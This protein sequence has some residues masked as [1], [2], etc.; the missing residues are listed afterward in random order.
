MQEDAPSDTESKPTRKPA[1]RQKQVVTEDSDEDI[2][3]PQTR[4]VEEN[5]GV[6]SEDDTQAMSSSKDTGR[7]ATPPRAVNNDGGDSD[8]SSVIDES[9]VKRR[10]QNTEKPAK[11]AKGAKAKA[12]PKAK[13]AKT[14]DDP[15]Q[16]EIKR[17][18]GWLVKCGIRKVWGKEL[19]KCDTPKD[20]IRHLKGLLKEAGMDGK[21][22][23]EK[24]A[25]IKEQREFAKDLEEIQAGAAAWGETISTGRPRRAAARPRQPVILPEDSGEEEEKAQGAK[26]DGT[27]DDDD[28][29]DEVHSDSGSDDSAGGQDDEN[30]DEDSE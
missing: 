28:D 6:E 22:S 17:L 2:A 1:R 26:E 27:E 18:Q 3:P 21:Y 13:V 10:K 14:E 29:D 11:V 12:Q 24:A 4:T 7:P 19:A 25:K 30:V 23:V 8:L 20:K 5:K 9:P 16:A 15:D